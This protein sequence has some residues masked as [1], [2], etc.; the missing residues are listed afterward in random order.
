MAEEFVMWCLTLCGWCCWQLNRA[1]EGLW[2]GTIGSVWCLKVWQI[3]RTSEIR[4]CY[5]QHMIYIQGAN[6]L[7]CGWVVQNTVTTLQSVRELL[8]S[9]W[10]SFKGIKSGGSIVVVTFQP[11]WPK[12]V[13]TIQMFSV[14]NRKRGSTIDSELNSPFRKPCSILALLQILV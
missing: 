13:E 1:Y 2:V 10:E 11:Y 14:F 8:L 12:C 7:E 9:K 5:K 4:K 6:M 3:T